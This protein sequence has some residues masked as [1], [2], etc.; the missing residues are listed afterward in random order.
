MVRLALTVRYTWPCHMDTNKC[1]QSVIHWKSFTTI[2][3]K[4]IILDSLV[5]SPAFS[6][7]EEVNWVKL[8][9]LLQS[10]LSRV[11]SYIHYIHFKHFKPP[12][13]GHPRDQKKCDCISLLFCF[14]SWPTSC[15]FFSFRIRTSELFVPC[16][17]VSSGVVIWWSPI[18]WTSWGC[19]FCEWFDRSLSCKM[20]FTLRSAGRIIRHSV[21]LKS[22]SLWLMFLAN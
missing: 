18:E 11:P 22:Q 16:E 14:A 20:W 2:Q 21:E 7:G 15:V 4:I 12:I 19:L 9:M 13:S 6:F 10:N 8:Q 5:C 17:L 3:L 1:T